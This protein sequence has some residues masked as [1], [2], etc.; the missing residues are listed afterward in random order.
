MRTRGMV[1]P[2]EYPRTEPDYR[3]HTGR[4]EKKLGERAPLG[5]CA[6]S[7]VDRKPPRPNCGWT[8]MTVA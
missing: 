7:W 6:V 8:D 2:D 4:D 1:A 5:A 3:G